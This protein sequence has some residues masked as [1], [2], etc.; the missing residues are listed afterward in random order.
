M[1]KIRIR[2][3]IL[4]FIYIFI[5]ILFNSCKTLNNVKIEKEYVHDTITTELTKRDSIYFQDSIIIRDKGDTVFVDKWHIR[6]KDKI[7]YRDSIQVKVEYKDREVIKEVVK[8]EKWY[9]QPIYWVSGFMGLLIIL[10]MKLR[11]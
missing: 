3:I 9:R 2:Y 10:L 6:Y 11:K 7:Q 1:N 8:K 5:L 4:L